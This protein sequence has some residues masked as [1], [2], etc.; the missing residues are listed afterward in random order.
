MSKKI[1]T[2]EIPPIEIGALYRTSI[3]PRGVDGHRKFS[4]SE[5]VLLVTARYRSDND[6]PKAYVEITVLTGEK[7]ETIMLRWYFFEKYWSKV[8]SMAIS[9]KKKQRF[10]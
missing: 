7:I 6:D 5:Y 9:K 8:W 2:P 10:L 3:P 1:M 4:P